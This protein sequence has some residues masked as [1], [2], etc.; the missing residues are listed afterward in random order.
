MKKLRVIV[1][2]LNKD[3]L[4]ISSYKC[5]KDKWIYI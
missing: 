3:K 4:E 1:E 5:S 2:L